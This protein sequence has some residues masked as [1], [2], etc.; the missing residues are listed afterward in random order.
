MKLIM[1]LPKPTDLFVSCNNRF[2]KV[3]KISDL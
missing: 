3:P 2:M 1:N